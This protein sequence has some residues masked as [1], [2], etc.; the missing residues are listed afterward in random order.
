MVLAEDLRQAV[1]QA[2]LQGK[3]TKQLETDSDVDEMLINIQKERKLLFDKKNAREEKII[4]IEEDEEKP[5]DIPQNW[6]WEKLGN[7]GIYKKGPFGSAL[8]K[9]MFVPKSE[10]TVKVYEQKNAIQKDASLGEYYITKEYFDSKMKGFVVESGDIIVSCAGTIG[11]TYIMPDNIEFGIINQ[12]LMRMNIVQSLDITYFLIYFDNVL[13]MEAQRGSKG[14]AIKNIPPFEVFKNMLI[15]IPPIEEQQRIVDKINEIMPKIDEYEKIEKEL[16]ILKKEFPTNMKDALLQAAMQGKLTEQL[17][18]DSSVDELL[19]VIRQEKEELIAQKEIK[20]E[21]P[22][23]DIEEEEIPFDIPENWRWVRLGNV[24]TLTR[25]NGIKRNEVTEVGFPCVRYGELYTTYKTK[26]DVAVSH[27]SKEIFNKSQKVHTNDILMA[28]TGENNFDIALALA[29]LGEEV[30]AMGGD[31]TR[32]S[33]HHMN[34]L[35]LVYVMNSS[36]AIHKKSEMAKG[37]IIVHISNDKLA[38]ILLPIPPIE[39]QNR[40]VERLEALLPLCEDLRE[41]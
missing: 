33:N 30:I 4:P 31:L 35:Y 38:T 5:Y 9:S 10:N 29:Y 14:S 6:R 15:P 25:G 13:K 27:T 1:L 3:L 39:E 34:P 23:P 16:E 24:G 36:Y 41:V 8:T 40:I 19:K 18:S 37:D 26:F 21:K 22:L 11:E 7:I 32:W 20:K 2:A 12:A 17:E 28:L